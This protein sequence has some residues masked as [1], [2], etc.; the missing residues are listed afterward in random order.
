[1]NRNAQNLQ[2]MLHLFIILIDSMRTFS[3]SELY[4]ELSTLALNMVNYVL[5]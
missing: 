2:Q 3:K 4:I 5:R 1:M